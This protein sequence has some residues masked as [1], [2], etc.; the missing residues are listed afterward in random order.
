M[1]N[2]VYG[3]TMKKLRNRINVIFVSSQKDYLKSTSKPSH[4]SHKK[5]GKNI[6]VICKSKVTLKF[7][8]PEY[9]GMCILDLSNVLMNE[10]HYGCIKNKVTN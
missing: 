3:K 7:N 8:K 9:V 2:V 4:M 6:V 1:N 10:L 5:V